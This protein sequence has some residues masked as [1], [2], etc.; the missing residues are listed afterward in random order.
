MFGNFSR[1]K[2]Y[3]KEL[4][5]KKVE[6]RLRAIKEGE[7]PDYPDDVNYHEN[8]IEVYIVR[9]EAYKEPEIDY[10]YLKDH[11]G[12]GRGDQYKISY[13]GKD[14]FYNKSKKLVLND[15]KWP[16]IMGLYKAFNLMSSKLGRVSCKELGRK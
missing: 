11:D 2:K 13:K 8:R 15:T 5:E 1:Q 7:C 14:V 9:R 3:L 16:V 4:S 12:E 6:A 10:W